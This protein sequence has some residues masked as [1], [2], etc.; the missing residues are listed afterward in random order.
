MRQEFVFFF[1]LYVVKMKIASH[2]FNL[3]CL[4]TIHLQ[5]IREMFKFPTGKCSHRFHLQ[6]I[7]QEVIIY[8]N[9]KKEK[10]MTCFPS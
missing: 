7:E 8:D 9:L 6:A 5:I 3:H 1:S 2:V 10:L 4:T